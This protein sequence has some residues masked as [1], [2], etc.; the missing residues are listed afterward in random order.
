LPRQEV[1][2]YAEDAG[3]HGDEEPVGVLEGGV[4]KKVWYALM[5]LGLELYEGRCILDACVVE[6]HLEGV[7]LCLE[8]IRRGLVGLRYWEVEER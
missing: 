2:D 1:H 3:V 7:F 5:M 8:S 6:H 4:G